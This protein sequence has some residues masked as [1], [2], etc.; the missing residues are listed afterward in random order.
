LEIFSKKYFF[1][2]NFKK[3]FFL[4]IRKRIFKKT[5]KKGSKT[6]VFSEKSSINLNPLQPILPKQNPLQ[7]TSPIYCPDFNRKKQAL[8]DNN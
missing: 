5:Q 2:K 1:D 7:P 6:K 4:K 3:K 8:D